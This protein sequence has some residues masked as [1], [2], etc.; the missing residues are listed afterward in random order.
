MSKP[1]YDWWPYAKG[2]IRR[3]PALKQEYDALHE[4]SITARY[5]G[6]PS[7]GGD[8]RTLERTA[9]RELPKTKQREFEAVKAAIARTSQLP[10]GKDRMQVV[11]LVLWKR[12][13][14]VEGA[15]LAVPCAVSTAKAYHGDFI[16]AV[17]AEYGLLDE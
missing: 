6:M 8:G 14:T 11:D 10:N 7:G 3:Y 12:S 16:R 5:S 15:A 17:A 1:R 4:Q 2:M 9:I 13:H